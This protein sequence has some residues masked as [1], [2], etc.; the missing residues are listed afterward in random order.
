MDMSVLDRFFPAT[1]EREKKHVQLPPGINTSRETILSI[2]HNYHLLAHTLYGLILQSHFSARRQLQRYLAS[3]EVS[4]LPSRSEPRWLALTMVFLSWKS[5]D[6]LGSA[7][8]F[9]GKCRERRMTIT[10]REWAL[11][12]Q[13]RRQGTIP[14]WKPWG[15]RAVDDRVGPASIMIIITWIRNGWSVYCAMSLLRRVVWARRWTSCV[16][17]SISWLKNRSGIDVTVFEYF[18]DAQLALLL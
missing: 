5:R 6:Q 16:S 3:K 10:P 18:I 7:S 4:S 12:G 14:W 1:F 13:Q 2:L 9:T 8:W 17:D 11:Y 15:S